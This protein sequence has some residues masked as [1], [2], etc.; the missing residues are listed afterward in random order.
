[1]PAIGD[2]SAQHAYALRTMARPE[3]NRS[4]EPDTFHSGGTLARLRAPRASTVV[5]PRRQGP[6]AV[7][8]TGS[9]MRLMET[10]LAVTAIAT[11][12]LIGL[13]RS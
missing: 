3:E 12:I 5:R 4:V 6:I 7:L 11:A 2:G 8:V 10:G 9:S 1:M 13:G